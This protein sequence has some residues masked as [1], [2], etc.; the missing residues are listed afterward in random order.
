MKK[1]LAILIAS[2][3]VGSLMG[4]VAQR[5]IP[6]RESH[7]GSES[8]EVKSTR[9]IDREDYLPVSRATSP[10]LHQ[11]GLAVKQ[12]LDSL[13]YET[14]NETGEYAISRK[15]LYTYN[16]QGNVL[17]FRQMRYYN[18]NLSAGT[19]EEYT[20]DANGNQA[21][22]IH[23][24][25][26]D[27]IVGNWVDNYKEENTFNSNGL[28]TLSFRNDWDK[29]TSQWVIKFKTENIFNPDGQGTLSSTSKW[30]KNL[31]R[32][33]V[34]SKVERT[35][36]LSGH[37][38][39][40]IGSYLNETVSELENTMKQES[41]YDI[42]GNRT[43]L[44]LYQWDTT[45]KR[46]ETDRKVEFTYNSAGILTK[47]VELFGN[48]Y[49][50][51]MIVAKWEYSYDSIG[52]ITQMIGSWNRF[53]EE[54]LYLDTK[55]EYLYDSIGTCIQ[56]TA[57]RWTEQSSEWDLDTSTKFIFDSKGNLKQEIYTNT[58]KNFN[59]KTTRYYSEVETSITAPVSSIEVKC[60]PNPASEYITFDIEDISQPSSVELIDMQGKKVVSQILPQNKQIQV[61]QLKSGMYFYRIQQNNKTYK[62]KVV[63]K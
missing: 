19:K 33:I 24:Y 62:G 43:V 37:Q 17:Q 20:Y 60:F 47:R 7:S 13:V 56:N 46:W 51:W 8:F 16:A 39:L 3:M 44:M 54:P 23:Y 26:W 27:K 10:I 28:I 40:S 12:Q 59:Y 50:G 35:Y 1:I 25:S 9:D 32:W 5:S 6:D 63:V 4:Q 36:D 49:G 42:N 14:P 34:I 38:T 18:Y 31:S 48:G 55:Y 57:Y 53:G 2:F 15:E 22:L 29:L 45:S 11:S 61:S 41:I 52:K 58:A 30:D 21:Q